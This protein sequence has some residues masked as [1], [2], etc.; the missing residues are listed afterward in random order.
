MVAKWNNINFEI[1]YNNRIYFI[2]SDTRWLP[3]INA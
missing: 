2:I 1:L 3:P